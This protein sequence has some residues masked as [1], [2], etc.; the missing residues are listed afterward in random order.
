MSL[1]FEG[2]GT[3]SGFDAGLSGF[4]GL[5]AVKSA[6]KTD[7]FSTSLAAGAS[8]AI[9]DLAITHEVA[10]A[11][12]RL[13]INVALGMAATSDAR[14]PFGVAVY[15]GSSFL[16]LADA[17][18]SRTLVSTNN[19]RLSNTATFNASGAHFSFVHT[20]GSGSKTYSVYAINVS[21]TT[22]SL[23]LNRTADDSDSASRGRGASS[24]VIQEVSV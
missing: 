9:T 15:D 10:N 3:I 19:T 20:P 23:Y 21:V 8:V 1:T 12:N 5:V 4:G 14:D 16:A 24:F 22:S 18:G 2:D 13:I 6:L 11:A 7:T 17:A